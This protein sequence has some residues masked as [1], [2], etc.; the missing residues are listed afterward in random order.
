MK[1]IGGIHAVSGVTV[2]IIS[3]IVNL[4][5]S[6]G[7]C[8][9]IYRVLTNILPRLGITGIN[10]SFDK[11]VPLWVVLLCA[12]VS[13]VCGCISSI[14]PYILYKNKLAKEQKELD[15]FNKEFL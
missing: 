7:I 6:R 15:A 5:L 1:E 9:A 13:A 3:F 12:A 14:I 2:F 10:A 4:V 11:F 8:Y